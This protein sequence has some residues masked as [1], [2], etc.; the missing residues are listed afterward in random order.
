MLTHQQSKL[1]SVWDL[2]FANRAKTLWH[3]T[4]FKMMSLAFCLSQKWFKVEPGKHFTGVTSLMHL[5]HDSSVGLHSHL[6]FQLGK[7]RYRENKWTR[8]Y[9]RMKN[10]G[11]W[12]WTRSSNGF[13]PSMLFTSPSART[14]A[15]SLSIMDLKTD[16]QMKP[17]KNPL[18]L[19]GYII[20]PF[21]A[22]ETS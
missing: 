2:C 12:P 11:P 15:L 21:S 17:K 7:L 13:G 10:A 20:S 8:I 18:S 14:C 5:Q 22:L 4:S 6:H 16:A 3:W 1:W 19:M 9:S